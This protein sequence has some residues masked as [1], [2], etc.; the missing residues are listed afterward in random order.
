MKLLLDFGNTRVKAAVSSDCG[1]KQIYSGPVVLGGLEHAVC[2]MEIDGGMWC[3]VRNVPDDVMAWMLS[4]GGWKS[5]R[6]R[7]GRVR[8]AVRFR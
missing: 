2:G 3:S 4:L 5:W 6:R 1:L 8:S 7:N